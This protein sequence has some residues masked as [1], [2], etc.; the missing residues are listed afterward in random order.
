MATKLI[1]FSAALMEYAYEVLLT[2][3]FWDHKVDIIHWEVKCPEISFQL[4]NSQSFTLVILE[5]C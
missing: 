2:G 5:Q 1:Y 3:I 4:A